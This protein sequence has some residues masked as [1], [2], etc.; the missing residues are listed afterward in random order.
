M[1]AALRLL[2]TS[3]PDAL[4]VEMGVPQAEPVGALHIVTHGAARA[5]G[6]A[7]VEVLTG[8]PSVRG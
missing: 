5:C 8:Q 4:V 7:A 1:S 2:L 6:L 3:R